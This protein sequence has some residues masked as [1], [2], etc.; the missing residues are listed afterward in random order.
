MQEI[1][2]K[3]CYSCGSDNIRIRD[4][5]SGG[6]DGVCGDCG[7]HD[8]LCRWNKRVPEDNRVKE[9]IGLENTIGKLVKMIGD[10]KDNSLRLDKELTETNADKFPIFW[11][12]S[13][14]NSY[15]HICH[16]QLMERLKN[17]FNI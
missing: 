9:I 12:D 16:V 8:F 15:A 11:E 14:E 3:R 1:E 2:T 7:A 10:L 6:Q 5:G 4:Y 13:N 17:E